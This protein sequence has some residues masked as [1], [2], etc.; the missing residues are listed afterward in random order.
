MFQLISVICT[1]PSFAF[2]GVSIAINDDIA[3]A[4]DMKNAELAALS[5]GVIGYASASFFFISTP[6]G[7]QREENALT[8][9]VFMSITSLFVGCQICYFKLDEAFDIKAALEPLIMCVAVGWFIPKMKIAR[10]YLRMHST[11][12]IDAHFR[13]S[14]TTVFGTYPPAIFLLAESM[15]CNFARTDPKVCAAVSSSNSTVSIVIIGMG[16]IFFFS[17]FSYA[18]DKWEDFV[19]MNNITFSSILRQLLSLIIW[20]LAFAI[21]GMRPKD[22]STYDVN[23]CLSARN[24]TDRGDDACLD[25]KANTV[26]IL[27]VQWVTL[28]LKILVFFALVIIVQIITNDFQYH[29]KHEKLITGD[30]EK[31]KKT[32][33][34]A[35]LAFEE[36]MKHWREYLSSGDDI[37]IAR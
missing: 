29:I 31:D 26:A 22:S 37:R 15:S 11:S 12:Q 17:N 24:E 4:S 7:M 36:Q 34:K 16:I 18:H 25:E 21:F 13:N 2:L 8:Y 19:T 35:W 6:R 3:N 20:G 9:F 28:A 10:N 14:F 33:S 27:L 30:L 1:F 32:M 23:A 5:L